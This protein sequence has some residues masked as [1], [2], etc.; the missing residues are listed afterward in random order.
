[1]EIAFKYDQSLIEIFLP[2]RPPFLMV[3]SIISYKSGKNPS[4]L[5]TYALKDEETPY[6]SKGPENH[7]PSIYI[8]EG[9]GQSCNLLVVF[10]ALEKKLLQAGHGINS[11][12]E[13]FRNIVANE[14]DEATG[15]LKD[16]L[17][18]R[19]VETYSNIGFMGA[20]DMKITGHAKRGQLILYEVQ[21]NQVFGTLF[22]SVVKAY[23]NK[24]LIAQ[25]TMVSASRNQQ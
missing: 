1:L 6:F 9:L 14:P 24:K 12:D 7:W 20:T 25:G 21:L 2:H 16:I 17:H 22:H 19:L 18:Q 8:M 23:T 3:N 5:T 11:M 13:V 15:L 4:L 10:Y